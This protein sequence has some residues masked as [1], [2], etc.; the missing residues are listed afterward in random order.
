[1]N[2]DRSSALAE[3]VRANGIARWVPALAW[4]RTYELGWLRGDV[5]AGL[6]LAAYLVPSGIGSAALA[7]LPPEAGLYACLFSGLVYWLFC[8]SRYMSVSVTSS[9]SL[10][11]GSSLG[12]FAGGDATRFAVLAAC[13]TLL[14]ALIA[15]VAW[16]V[17]AGVIVN[18]ISESAMV[19]FKCGVALILAVSQMPALLGI[20]GAPG[21]FW[22]RSAFLVE[23]LN[24]THVV[25]AAVGLGAL[26]ALILGKICLPN[27][28][29]SL[30][31]VAVGIAASAWF[32][33][34][35]HGV[36]LLGDVPQGFPRL[37][38]PVVRWSDWDELLPLAL[39]CF[40]LGAV[41]TAAIGRMFAEKR[42]G[43]FDSTQEF[44]AIAGANLLAGLGHGFPVSG[45]TS[46]SVVN[47][48][49]G[50]RTPLS[51][52]LASCVVLL[53]VVSLSGLLRDLP[54][55]V[56]AA[57]VIV[58]VGGLLRVSAL[59]ALWREDR[60]E[61]VVAMCAL[62]AALGSGLLRGVLIGAII[63]LVQLLRRASKPH[64]ALLGRIPGTRRYSDFDRHTDNEIVSGVTI[65]RPESGLVYFNIEHVHDA[66]IERVHAQSP[67]PK[68]VV[69]DLGSSPY[70]DMQS[71]H[72]LGALADELTS[73][74][75][76]IQVVECHSAVRDRLRNE[77]VDGKLGGV[78]RFTSVADAM[79]AF[80]HA[81]S[82]EG[83]A[84]PRAGMT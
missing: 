62:I 17:R 7:N 11:I 46:Q 31:V 77:G 38:W 67:R 64:V 29:V 13:T 66:L 2:A 49:S 76:R 36:S 9:I 84:S 78:N 12:V 54:Q 42:G 40:I 47:E 34:G 83:A 80:L 5:V 71:A 39:A 6:T 20:H 45:G 68:L 59:K 33:L 58:A 74:G 26:G 1:M 73:L 43:R 57:V 8:S 28:P 55:T 22:H 35:E 21:N 15:F 63:S 81:G 23:H 82:R 16:L 51:T 3:P 50:A 10:L 14:V 52:F 60:Q 27:K 61:F 30:L 72:A 37:A 44:L 48:S 65:L 70:V 41:E 25:A 69:L 79:D 32:R 75:I 4:L 56:V 19:G 18:F 53:V 24:E